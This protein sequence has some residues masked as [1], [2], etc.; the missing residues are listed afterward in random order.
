M[1]DLIFKLN[2]FALGIIGIIL[3]ILLANIIILFKLKKR[4]KTLEG[5]IEDIENRDNKIFEFKLFNSM[6]K[7]YKRAL[8]KKIDKI[9][10]LSIVDKNIQ[11]YLDK[12]LLLERILKKSVSI[13][14]ILGLIG[15]FYGLTLSI[16]E[17]VALL[18][19]A[20][21]SVV[22]DVNQVTNGLILAVRSMSVAFVTSLFGITSS[23][24]LTFLNTFINVENLRDKVMVMSEE[25]LDNHLST[26][27]RRIRNKNY[28]KS[29]VEIAFNNFGKKIEDNLNE[30]TDA[31]T[32]RLK[33]S[34]KG[35]IRSAESIEKSIDKFDNSLDKFNDNVR[36]F[37]EFNHHLKT[38]IERMSVAFDDLTEDLK[39]HNNHKSINSLTNSIEKLSQRVK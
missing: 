5:D 29:N 36:D 3:V 16:G 35:M 6:V 18:T 20:G 30:I 11:K 33:K 28:D 32:H 38:N 39:E 1:L 12:E 26:P 13:M 19:K 21:E 34:S 14:I 24:I 17:L 25:Y 31:I 37:S 22:G 15:T 8:D 7:D 27:Q 9:N 10:T 23:I 4:Y 2:P